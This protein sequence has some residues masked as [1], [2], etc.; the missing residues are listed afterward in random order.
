MALMHTGQDRE[1]ESCYVLQYP[2][3]GWDAMAALIWVPLVGP[4]E[5]HSRIG[6]ERPYSASPCVSF[7]KRLQRSIYDALN[8]RPTWAEAG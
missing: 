2:L 4:D 3:E 1:I 6:R 5:E 7:Q 8:H